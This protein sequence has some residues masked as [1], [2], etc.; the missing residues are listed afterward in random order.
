MPPINLVFKPLVH[1]SIFQM[2]W[3]TLSSLALVEI[4]QKNEEDVSDKAFDI[5]SQGLN[6]FL[7]DNIGVCHEASA[8]DC[9]QQIELLKSQQG[10]EK[11]DQTSLDIVRRKL[12]AKRLS[13]IELELEQVIDEYNAVK[14]ELGEVS[15]QDQDGDQDELD[16]KSE[17]YIDAEDLNISGLIQELAASDDSD[18]LDNPISRVEPKQEFSEPQVEDDIMVIEL[19]SKTPKEK[20]NQIIAANSSQVVEEDDRSYKQWKKSILVLLKGISNHK[21][22]HVFSHP[23]TDDIAPSYSKVV[24]HP[25]DLTAIRKRIDSGIIRSDLEFARDVLL[26]FQNAF[27]YNNSDHEIYKLAI[28]M[29]N[30]CLVLMQQQ[31]GASFFMK[32]EIDAPETRQPRTRTLKNFDKF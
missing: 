24:S 17:N 10:L 27:I 31:F 7:R 26:M 23:V 25:M 9:K 15:K 8:S 19:D 13:E 1:F 18:F 4:C 14:A 22:A 21:W 28:E 30:D 20:C 3:T 2:N 11:F 32:Y 6:N 12:S 29:Q 16:L 5:V